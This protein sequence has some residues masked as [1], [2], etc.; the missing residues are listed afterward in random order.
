VFMAENEFKK[1]EALG[2][3]K[4]MPKVEEKQVVEFEKEKVIET[5]DEFR[6]ALGNAQMD[7]VEYIE[8]SEKLFKHL[9][10][11]HKSKFLTYGDPG[12]KVY[13]VGTRDKYEAEQ[14]MSADQF[15]EHTTREKM[16]VVG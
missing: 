3:I 15:Y 10:K 1:S 14:D 13:A 9:L 4:T 6:I 7:D 12:I 5:P 2:K 8:V 11:N 16:N